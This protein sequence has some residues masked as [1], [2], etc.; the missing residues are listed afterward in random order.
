MHK[1]N[2]YESLSMGK[3]AN[4]IFRSMPTDNIY[5][6][7]QSTFSNLSNFL[8]GKE[9]ETQL[10]KGMCDMLPTQ[11]RLLS[12]MWHSRESGT[13]TADTWDREGKSSQGRWRERHGVE[14]GVKS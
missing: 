1:R 10:L 9:Q 14:E 7:L 12:F 4:C 6:V 3:S 5:R 13:L 11:G 8:L 2:A